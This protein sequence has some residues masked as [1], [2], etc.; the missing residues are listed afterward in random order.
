MRAIIQATP[1]DT[2]VL[3]L[4]ET[5]T[6]EPGPNQ[7]RV[8]VRAAGLNRAD[9]LQ[10]SGLYPAPPGWPADIPGLEYAGEVESVDS[11]V[12]RWD[13][14][15]R[16]M[17]L[18][19]GG[20]H[21][22]YLVVHEDEVLPMPQGMS[23][24]DA[25]SIPEAFLTA[26]D[27]LVTRGRVQPGERTLIHAVGS[28]VGTAAIQLVRLLRAIS[29]GTSRNAGKL[30]RATALG[31]DE[32]IDTSTRNFR[33]GLTAPVNVIL[34]VLG[35]PAFV[36][37]LEALAPRG[38]L[39]LLGH[40]QGAKVEGTLGP[41]LRKRLEV[42]GS[43]MRTRSLDERVALARDFIAYLLPAFEAE[44]LNPVVSATYPFTSIA[45]A[46]QE[47]EADQNFGKIVLVW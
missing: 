34:D 27:A 32:A 19:G 43:V 47:M 41:I 15:D 11:E 21:A 35:G 30:S 12:T 24:A 10:R 36:D 9:I 17:G 2:S 28:G 20:A 5:E 8:R 22:E 25:A 40:L 18:V 33:E 31:L 39:V 44:K 4:R 42:I 3:E 45:E 38:R 16:V 23:W 13:L 46:H 7:I 14:T 26:W 37:N 1:G 29:V 6:P